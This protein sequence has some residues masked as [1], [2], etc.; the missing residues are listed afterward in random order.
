MCFHLNACCCCYCWLVWVLTG[1]G[2]CVCMCVNGCVCERVWV[3]VSVWGCC[4]SERVC[5]MPLMMVNNLIAL[6]KKSML[7]TLGCC[8]SYCCSGAAFHHNSFRPACSSPLRSSFFNDVHNYRHWSVHC[9]HRAAV[10]W[11]DYHH[12]RCGYH[13]VG[14]SCC[15]R[16]CS[17]EVHYCHRQHAYCCGP[18]YSCCCHQS[19]DAGADHYACAAFSLPHSVFG[20]QASLPGSTGAIKELDIKITIAE[21]LK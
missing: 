11:T 1:M 4:L 2:V 20:H 8:C 5:D 19:T 21:L 10:R 9:R 13:C 16:C 6:W 15:H 12:H 14:Q 18:Y 3:C 7:W 17:Y